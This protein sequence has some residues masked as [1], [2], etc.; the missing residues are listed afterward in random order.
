MGSAHVKPVEGV[1]GLRGPELSDALAHLN[2]VLESAPFRSSPRS[3]QFLQYVV[4]NTLEGHSELL[5]ER[6]I[7]E[8]VFGRP[9]D[10]DT[11]QD[12]IVRVKANEVRRRLA[13]YYD[14]TP[15]A[16]HRFDLPSGSYA[17]QFHPAGASMPAA[18]IQ[19]RSSS[20]ATGISTLKRWWWALAIATLSAVVVAMPR[21]MPTPSPFTAFWA[22]FLSGSNDLIICMPTPET[23]RIYGQDKQTLIQTLKPRPPDQPVPRLPHLTSVEIVSEPGM[24][25]GLGDAQAMT[26]LYSL[27]AS[28]GKT[29]KFRIGRE[30]TFTE[31]RSAA[32]VLIGGFTNRWT[33]DLTKDA[34]YVF[35]NQQGQVG[36]VDTKTGEMIC[37]K[38]RNWEPSPNEDCAMVTRLSQ[39]KTGFPVLI[40]AGVDHF[41]TFA[42]G[43]FLTRPAQLE[44][45]LR[46]MP[47]GWE[48]K[49]L[50][51]VFRVEI[52]RDNIGPPKILATHVW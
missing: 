12:S 42:V 47:A 43:E 24:F 6:L 34:R 30:T 9:A 27:A 5:K 22:P 38:Q 7:G 18:R 28:H 46:T 26:L 31:L 29:P 3:R 11:G 37:R 52:V 1:P 33:L 50:Q 51:I 49:N 14:L 40:G 21:L 10:Y 20:M 41:G 2:E 4:E 15:H 48:Y 16:P 19:V 35:E 45:A 8:K 23:Y 44:S 39:A 25:V 13:Q 36:I 17:V 32:A